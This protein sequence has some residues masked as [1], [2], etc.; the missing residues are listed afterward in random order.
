MKRTIAVALILL[1]ASTAALAD[2]GW[3]GGRGYY[4]GGSWVAPFVTGAVIGGAL[5]YAATP[6]YYPPVYVTPPPVY[7]AP[8][9]TYR[10]AVIYDQ[11]CNCNRTVLIQ[12]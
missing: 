12:N 9:A 3:H 10:Q 7:V 11:N 2:H 1:A 8:P 4:G 5:T 6:R